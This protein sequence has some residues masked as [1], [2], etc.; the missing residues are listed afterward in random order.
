MIGSHVVAGLFEAAA[1]VAIVFLL[2]RLS[3]TRKERET[4]TTWTFSPAASATLIG[5][6]LAVALLTAPA[7]GLASPLPDAYE[8]AIASTSASIDEV[9]NPIAEQGLAVQAE[10]WQETMIG[11]MPTTPGFVA[12]CSTVIAGC[13]A[14]ATAWFCAVIRRGEYPE[15]CAT[16]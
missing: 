1:T 12:I 10:R 5:L 14:A 7:L 9:S 6:S 4:P 13:M 8:A 3:H 11:A 15:S 2:V 16:A